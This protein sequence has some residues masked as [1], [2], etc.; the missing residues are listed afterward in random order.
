MTESKGLFDETRPPRRGALDARTAH[1]VFQ[2][3]Q[4]QLQER[5]AEITQSFAS[6]IDHIPT[7]ADRGP[8]N[9][10]TS[11]LEFQAIND[12]SGTLQEIHRHLSPQGLFLGAM[13]GGASLHELRSCLMEAEIALAGG[14]SPRV[15]PMVA[16]EDMANLLARAGFALP[17]LDHETLTLCYDNLYDLMGDLRSCGCTNALVARARSFTSRHLFEVTQELY[18]SRFPAQGGGI[19]ATIEILFLHGWKS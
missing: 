18:V 4:S 10:V 13:I 7:Q 15:A 2:F 3:A 14:A 8:F 12:L 5:L 9:L 6:I 1:P 19:T 17:V 16:K 11:C